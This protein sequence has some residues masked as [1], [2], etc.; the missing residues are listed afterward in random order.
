MSGKPIARFG[1]SLLLFNLAGYAV[2]TILA[3]QDFSISGV[4]SRYM[5]GW[6]A[7]E[8]FVRWFDASVSLS[9]AAALLAFSIVITRRQLPRESSEVV[10]LMQKLVLSVLLF[11]IVFSV[12]QFAVYPRVVRAG[13]E[14]VLRTQRVEA[15]RDSAEAFAREGDIASAVTALQEYLSLW[16][17][18]DEAHQQ[19]IEL[20]R[21]LIITSEETEE[22]EDAVPWL[23]V[24]EQQAGDLVNRAR[25]LFEEEDFFSALFYARLAYRLNPSREDIAGFIQQIERQIG[26]VERLDE[27]GLSDEELAE[28][29]L[30][31]EKQR[32]MEALLRNDPVTAYFIF[33]S[34]E[35][36]YPADLDVQRYSRIAVEG[37]EELGVPGV[38]DMTYFISEAQEMLTLPGFT[39]LTL[40]HRW[41]N[42]V[43]ELLYIGKMVYGAGNTYFRDIESITMLPSGEVTRHY[44]APYGKLVSQSELPIY[45]T[46][47]GIQSQNSEVRELPVYYSGEPS[48]EHEML[49]RL[50]ISVR[51]LETF[52]TISNSQ[53]H[54]P[55]DLYR[56]MQV[57]PDYGFDSLVQAVHFLAVLLRPFTFFLVVFS[58]IGLGIRWHGRYY[59]RSPAAVWVFVPLLPFFSAYVVDLY[60]YLV[61]I[62]VGTAIGMWGFAVGLTLLLVLQIIVFASAMLFTTRE[63]IVRD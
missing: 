59:G 14:Y 3:I 19:L 49:M 35:D 32:G 39:D 18:D 38:Q 37:D 61:Q 47:H 28:R 29:H 44:F 27:E 15:L 36:A 9:A 54:T 50:D 7:A 31:R 22:T 57:L 24:E 45:I 34:L 23:A 6:I 63:C 60:E 13:E 51:D 52:D 30:F 41:D 53:G 25:R 56:S 58:A 33:Q 10:K 55:L 2:F 8:S 17:E 43:R 20:Q 4:A 12:F 5:A 46:L 11:T 21:E 48:E 26:A 62:F 16:G 42:E 1:F 40:V